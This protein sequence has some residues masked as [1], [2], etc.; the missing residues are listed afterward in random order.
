MA[1]KLVALRMREKTFELLSKEF[2]EKKWSFSEGIHYLCDWYLFHKSSDEIK[3]TFPGLFKFVAN[4]L[5]IKEFRPN[6]E[7]KEFLTG[8]APKMKSVEEAKNVF[9]K[10]FCHLLSLDEF[11]E[12]LKKCKKTNM[13]KN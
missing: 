8:F 5:L 9:N 4:H 13:L 10:R 1:T 6:K 2:K 12:V 11:K 7:E 3:E